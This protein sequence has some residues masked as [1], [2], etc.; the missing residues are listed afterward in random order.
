MER[1]LLVARNVF[2]AIL[3]GKIVY[4]WLLGLAL[5]FLQAA[6]AVFMDFGNEAMQK[7][8]RARAVAGGLSTW[9]TMCIAL[10]IF[11]GASAIGTEISRKTIVN[12]FSRPI[13]RWEF[14]VGKWIGVQCFA[15]VSMAVGLL[16]SFGLSRYLG[17]QFETKVLWLALGGTAA[18]ILLY[19]GLSIAFSTLLSQGVA[20]ALTVIV[21]FLPG[22]V[23]LLVNNT[24]PTP[25]AIGVV[26]DYVIPPGYT[27]HYA[28]T[29]DAPMPAFGRGGRGNRG[30]GGPGAPGSD[31]PP[32]PQANTNVGPNI[33]YNAEGRILLQNVAYAGVFFA[34]GCVIFLRRDLRLT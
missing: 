4:L 24:D 14:L 3:H 22:V 31:I 11:V 20:G 15:F 30:G 23:T 27:S 9:S 6:P 32:V 8:M 5:M 7:A 33:D 17:A 1:I 18:A 21:A 26:L 29:I 28:E 13:H 19:G 16:V 2:R 25:H 12:V 10:A 34:L